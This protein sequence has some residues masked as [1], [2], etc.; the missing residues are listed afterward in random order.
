MSLIKSVKKIFQKKDTAEEVLEKIK[1]L[2]KKFHSKEM[3]EM[4]Y[5]RKQKNLELEFLCINLYHYILKMIVETKD[6]VNLNIDFLDEKGRGYVN[7]LKRLENSIVEKHKNYKN[8]K[9][10]LENW[11][12]YLKEKNSETIELNHS[13]KSVVRANKAKKTKEII[14]LLEKNFSNKEKSKEDKL[15]EELFGEFQTK[16]SAKKKK[17][18]KEIKK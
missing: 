4:E 12:L 7:L 15:V 1:E 18:S 10:N 3:L 9:I 8:G 17:K 13:I 5:Q 2:E 11:H 16:T 6:F 14:D